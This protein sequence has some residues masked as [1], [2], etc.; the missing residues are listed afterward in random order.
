MDHSDDGSDNGRHEASEIASAPAAPSP[1]ARLLEPWLPKSLP[2][3][4]PLPPI[5]LL[6][7]LPP[8]AGPTN[9]SPL[10]PEERQRIFQWLEETALPEDW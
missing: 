9:S 8:T 4:P 7:P 5:P 1:S 3:L 2:C 10:L 6:P